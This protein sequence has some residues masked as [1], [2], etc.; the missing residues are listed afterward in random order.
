MTY[1]LSLRQEI[2]AAV[3]E[4]MTQAA[5]AHTFGVSVAT[6]HRYLRQRSLTGHLDPRPLP[7]RP[8]RIDCSDL[9]ALAAQLAAHPYATIGEHGRLWEQSHGQHVYRVTMGRAIRELGWSRR[10]SR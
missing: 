5:A 4:G 9:P 10:Y 1:P 2:V 3:D 6:V 8:K 7:G